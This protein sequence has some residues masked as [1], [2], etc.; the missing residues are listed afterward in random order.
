VRRYLV[1]TNVFVYARGREHPYRDPCRAVLKAVQA[2]NVLLEASVEL[3]QEVTHLLLR[4]TEDRFSALDEVDEI[5]AACRVHPLDLET[6]GIAKELL[7][8]HAGLGTRDAVHAATALQVGLAQILST[9]RV[10][11]G[12]EGV[13][14]VDPAVMT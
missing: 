6:W 13:R 8:S 9:D 11:D 7:R 5:R 3:L 2:G 1:D 4:R 14:R 12:I 10:F